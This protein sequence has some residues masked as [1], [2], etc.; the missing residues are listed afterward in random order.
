MNTASPDRFLIP[1]L[2][3]CNFVI[4]VGA[5]VI[6]GLLEPLG[7]DLNRSPAQ[8]GQLMTVY[9][10][11]YALLSPIL[12]ALT[13]S[14]GRRRVMTAGFVLFALA[15]AVSAMAPNFAVLS[16][17]R[18]I[19]AAGAGLFTPLAAAVAAALYPEEQRARVLAAVF[20]GLTLSQVMGVPAGSWIAYTFGWRWALWLVLALA[21]PCT[22]LIWTRVPLGLRFQPV[23]M[24]DLRDTLSEGRLMLAIGFT[25]TFIGAQY[26]L[27]T[28]IAPL[29]SETMGFSR[30]GITMVLMVS[31]VGAVIGNILGGLLSD[32]FGWRITLTGLCLAQVILM[33]VFS[34]LPLSE[35]H[36]FIA[37]LLWAMCSWSFMAAQQTRLINIAG[38]RAPVVLALNA[39]AVYAGAA[40]GSAIGGTMISGYGIL[41]LGVT[42]GFGAAIALIHLTLSA[43]LS[44][45]APLS[46]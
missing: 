35:T 27:F 31:G 16:G 44:P 14:I 19:A 38:R 9:A 13:G 28:Y 8:A 23:S 33:P 4:G 41:S 26:V 22:L 32:R 40:I 12:V 25:A 37:I 29:L 30:N 11:A 3:A 45:Q 1:A 34:F 24:R 39:A 42:A 15:A 46:S 5:F 36:L 20:F 21:V 10:V 18:I 17:A 2:S 7:Q 6:I 43:W